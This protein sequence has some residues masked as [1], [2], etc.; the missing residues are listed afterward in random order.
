M[1]PAY[2]S[3]TPASTRLAA[4]HVLPE[5][6]LFVDDQVA[7]AQQPKWSGCAPVFREPTAYASACVPKASAAARLAPPE[8]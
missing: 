2:E 8:P 3:P 1:R 7:T 4:L 5:D 6:A